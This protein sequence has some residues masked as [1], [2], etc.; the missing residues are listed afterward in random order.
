MEYHTKKE[1]YDQE[2]QFGIIT[3]YGAERLNSKKF[4]ADSITFEK[5]VSSFLLKQ[6]DK[7]T[8]S[9]KNQT[10]QSPQI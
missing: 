4:L 10:N 8:G 5:K 7:N 9:L 3:F 2:P 6:F 1:N